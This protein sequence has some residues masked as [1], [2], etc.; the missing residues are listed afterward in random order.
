MSKITQEEGF[1]KKNDLE[2]LPGLIDL[3][4]RNV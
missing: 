2:V 3:K 4:N 1:V